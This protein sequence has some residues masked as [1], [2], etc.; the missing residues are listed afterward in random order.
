MASLG[1]VVAYAFFFVLV[2]SP[3]NAFQGFRLDDYGRRV[4]LEG[5]TLLQAGAG[6]ELRFRANPESSAKLDE[7]LKRLVQEKAEVGLKIAALPAIGP[8]SVT[9]TEKDVTAELSGVERLRGFQ[10]GSNLLN[11][12][13]MRMK[14]KPAENI[15][16]IEKLLT[17]LKL[18]VSED[19]K[20]ALKVFKKVSSTCQEQ[21]VE[22]ES[23][24][25]EIESEISSATGLKAAGLKIRLA[26]EKRNM[27]RF[28]TSCATM[29]RDYTTEENKRQEH[30]RALAIADSII[31]LPGLKIA[32]GLVKQMPAA[33]PQNVDA[34]VAIPIKSP[35]EKQFQNDLTDEAGFVLED[36]L[37]NEMEQKE[38][39]SVKKELSLVIQKK[40]KRDE[41][42]E[43]KKL[44]D[45][46]TKQIEHRRNE[47]A[48]IAGKEKARVEALQQKYQLALINY[49]DANKQRFAGRVNI[50]SANEHMANTKKECSRLLVKAQRLGNSTASP[51]LEHSTADSN[52][53]DK[54][55]QTE[56]KL[57]QLLMEERERHIR[58]QSERDAATLRLND[59]ERKLTESDVA[60]KYAEA[61]LDLALS[62]SPAL[63]AALLE[64]KLANTK[65]VE[66]L[67]L[68]RRGMAETKKSVTLSTRDVAEREK[69]VAEAKEKVN[70]ARKS[71]DVAF[72][73]RVE[74]AGAAHAKVDVCNA[75]YA[76]L[77][78]DFK[79]LQLEQVHM[80][81][82]VAKAEV[83]LA[84]AKRMLDTQQVADKADAMELS[85]ENQPI[86]SQAPF[87][88]LACG[89]YL[90][91]HECLIDRGCGWVPNV[92]CI[93]GAKDGPYFYDGDISRW[94]FDESTGTSCSVY[95]DCRQCAR[96]GCGWCGPR[97]TCTEGSVDGPIDVDTCPPEF[98]SQ[99]VHKLGRTEHACP[100]RKILFTES[101]IN[102]LDALKVALKARKNMH[103]QESV[104]AT[105]EESIG[106]LKNNHSEYDRLKIGELTRTI[107]EA[108]PRY[109]NFKFELQ[110]AVKELRMAEKG[111]SKKFSSSSHLEKIGLTVAEIKE[112]EEEGYKSGI[113]ESAKQSISMRGARGATGPV[114]STG[115]NGTNV[116]RDAVREIVY[117]TFKAVAMDEGKVRRK[118]EDS[119]RDQSSELKSSV[120]GVDSGLTPASANTTIPENMNFSSNKN[121]SIISLTNTLT[122]TTGGHNSDVAKGITNHSTNGK[123]EDNEGSE[124]RN[125]ARSSIAME[126]KSVESESSGESKTSDTEMAPRSKLSLPTGLST[127]ESAAL[128]DGLASLQ[129]SY[130]T[131]ERH[132]AS[133]VQAFELALAEEKNICDKA[134]NASLALNAA[135]V[136]KR[137]L[138][139][140]LLNVE[141]NSSAMQEKFASLSDSVVQITKRVNVEQ[142][143]VEDAKRALAAAPQQTD[144][145]IYIKLKSVLDTSTQTFEQL[146]LEKEMMIADKDQAASRKIASIAAVEPLKAM[147]LL[148]A[149]DIESKTEYGENMQTKE[150]PAA[151]TRRITV[152]TEA[153]KRKLAYE[154]THARLNAY[155]IT[156]DGKKNELVK[157]SSYSLSL[158]NGPYISAGYKGYQAIRNAANKA[159]TIELRVKLRKF[160]AEGAI[161][162]LVASVAGST[163]LA[164]QGWVLGAD[165]NGFTF[166]FRRVGSNVMETIRSSEPGVQGVEISLGKW[167]HVAATFS[168]TQVT[169]FV[170]GKVTSSLKIPKS[171]LNYDF[172]DVSGAKS[173]RKNGRFTV[174][175]MKQGQP[176]DAII[177]NVA[178]WSRTLTAF[179]VKEHSCS[180]SVPNFSRQPNLILQYTF[181]PGVV[182]GVIVPDVSPNRLQGHIYSPM[183]ANTHSYSDHSLEWVPH[184]DDAVSLNCIDTLKLLLPQVA[185][186]ALR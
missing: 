26:D 136:K 14:E 43:L 30:L 55:K 66:E 88:A 134:K 31:N 124:Q 56:L 153:N 137:G 127:V 164:G 19:Q 140:T 80:E 106:K 116:D 39:V 102:Q 177:D 129:A 79:T 51:S 40:K 76:R 72:E 69:A 86:P 83:H 37:E 186:K 61:R 154:K 90:H 33:K 75:N 117:S 95:K 100:V 145:P 157:N 175:S 89:L 71:A 5:S 82:S 12:I 6:Q 27:Q 101:K 160:S 85:L 32:L 148:A 176:A 58:V 110:A 114:G 162:G 94:E 166:S 59:T 147:I 115:T 108:R 13:V 3:T 98:M 22:T 174:G 17:A 92:G 109:E 47:L 68:A 152:E 151:R 183:H 138:L 46:K 179:E 165:Q 73:A 70:A 133:Q 99:W 54:A 62:A 172:V 131:A 143:K 2:V 57:V 128:A 135:E 159:L 120:D 119:Q 50:M 65:L 155:I 97:L 91:E 48:I 78:K 139:A 132:W 93:S 96:A 146:K 1:H 15:K 123:T 77:E 42:A 67:D 44:F 150:C 103:E 24:V 181:G 121:S 178:V 125:G 41:L 63:K 9:K 34:I 113:G 149:K 60:L 87:F 21:M 141:K 4:P 156:M 104:L 112:A 167:Y 52:D 84:K 45:E 25:K 169:L 11:K 158:H 180:L 130:R 122:N 16:P 81:E 144:N 20:T 64:A 29:Q 36:P 107:E 163:L 118:S 170:N 185:S 35:V 184:D 28:T 126:D 171:S 168:P 182:P 111:I 74:H 49:T 18:H 7:K 142:E 173:P 38:D 23:K 8:E 161:V 10:A 105:A 53:Y